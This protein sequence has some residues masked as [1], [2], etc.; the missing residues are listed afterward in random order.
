MENTVG[1]THPDETNITGSERDLRAL[2]RD[3]KKAED[4]IEDLTKELRKSKDETLQLFSDN[5][6]LRSEITIL[7]EKVEQKDL[8]ITKLESSEHECETCGFYRS[9]TEALQEQ[10][11]RTQGDLEKTSKNYIQLLEKQGATQKEPES[12]TGSAF[13]KIHVSDL[14][15]FSGNSDLIKTWL[16]Q[17]DTAKDIHNLNDKDLIRALPEIVTGRAK[18]W[19]QSHIKQL[20]DT[21]GYNWEAW[22]K[23]FIQQFRDVVKE[24]TLRTTYRSLNIKSFSSFLEYANRK[25]ALRSQ[26]YGTEIPPSENDQILIEDCLQYL[27]PN[28]RGLFKTIWKDYCNNDPPSW[29]DF[30]RGITAFLSTHQDRAQYDPCILHRIPP[31]RNISSSTIQKSSSANTTVSTPA[32]K[33]TTQSSFRCFQCGSPDHRF[34]ACEK[35]KALQL[36]CDIC[37]MKNHTTEM[38]QSRQK[39]RQQSVSRSTSAQVNTAATITEVTEEQG[40]Q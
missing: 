31:A 29:T 15:P 8:F 6:K 27:T 16:A 40:F 33:Q 35:A 22:K 17:L 12:Y 11:L 23:L 19:L 10:L 25:Y 26:L 39:F 18:D 1:N 5:I 37:Q 4:T 34:T 30:I 9:E 38:H 28:A 13:H 21:H 36:Q 7:T 3:F 20:L 24:Q 14:P 32:D 2:Q